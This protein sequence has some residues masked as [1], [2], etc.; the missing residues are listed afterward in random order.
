MK[1]KIFL[2][3]LFFIL[4]GVILFF[5]NGEP[6]YFIVFLLAFF[7]IG[8]FLI[9]ASAYKFLILF[10]QKK[11]DTQNISRIKKW[12]DKNL[13]F[14]LKMI[15]YHFVCILIF[16]IYTSAAWDGLLNL[17]SIDSFVIY[18]PILIYEIR[19]NSFVLVLI[20]FYIFALPFWTSIDI[21][22]Y[23]VGFLI[24]FIQYKINILKFNTKMVGPSSPWEYCIASFLQFE[25]P[26]TIINTILLYL[27]TLILTMTIIKLSYKL[28]SCFK[29]IKNNKNT[30]IVN[31]SKRLK[32]RKGLRKWAKTFLE[33]LYTI[34]IYI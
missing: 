29:C 5:G 4:F 16:I 30:W 3:I 31:N 20:L 21:Y 9:L 32:Y 13:N 24:T 28:I 19:N 15:I 18:T 7:P 22:I 17:S 10:F 25:S 23:S 11:G 34:L 8:A 12:V 14:I 26:L 27:F 2:M 33:P 6:K 1:I